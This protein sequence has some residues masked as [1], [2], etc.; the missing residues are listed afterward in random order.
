MN[1]T[2]YKRFYKVYI[3][4]RPTYLGLNHY[5]MTNRSTS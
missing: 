1:E 3:E 5:E 4:Q 2:N